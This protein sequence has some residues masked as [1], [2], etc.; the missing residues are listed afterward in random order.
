MT[1]SSSLYTFGPIASRG[2]TPAL[3][4]VLVLVLSVVSAPVTAQMLTGFTQTGDSFTYSVPGQTTVTGVLLKPSGDGPFPAIIISHGK[5]ATLTGFTKAKAQQMVQWGYVCIGVRYTHASDDPDFSN[6][7]MEGARPENLRRAEACVKILKSLPYVRGNRIYA[8]GNSMGAF[9]TI[10]LCG[11]SPN[12]IRAAVITAGGIIP[13]GDAASPTVAEASTIRCPFLMLH[14]EDDTT[15]NPSQSLLLKQTLDNINVENQR[16]TYPGIDHNLHITLSSEVYSKIQT[17]FGN[18]GASALETARVPDRPYGIYVLDSAAGTPYGT[19]TLRDANIRN[20]SWL[21]GYTLRVPWST[22]ETTEDVFD[23]TII[24]NVLS[25]LP[26][27]QKLSLILVPFEPAYVSSHAGVTTWTDTNN[28]SQP[29][30]RAVPW[31]PYL[32]ERRRAFLHTLANHVTSGTAF[33]DQL[34]FDAIDP[35]LPGGFT[36]IR[37][38]NSANLSSLPGYTRANLLAAVEDELRSLT[39]EFPNQFVQL[40]FWKVTDTNH[41][42]EAW[43]E[44][45]D[46][47]LDHFDGTLRPKVG[48]FMENLAASRPAVNGS[49]VTGYPDTTFA[50]PLYSSQSQTWTAFQAL[51]SWTAP[52]TGFDKVA[53]AGAADGI[54]YGFNTYGSRYFEL[55]VSD[56]DDPSQQAALDQWSEDL[57]PSQSAIATWASY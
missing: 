3:S 56:I 14:G 37:N 42:P 2:V 29:V 17:W 22:L 16:I 52:F 6:I 57:A 4:A 32:R 48:F 36:G 26:S 19:G 33:R 41:S 1:R 20:Y 45:R 11:Q 12:L 44:I 35:Y 28:L 39:T 23:F 15:V 7:S 40:G 13:S 47:I 50:D 46:T 49:P 9:V 10:G 53:N 51:T 34:A 43:T 5:S 31:D 38:P 18:H 30:V 21:R 25:K 54:A 24:D 27:G 8:Y 55:Y